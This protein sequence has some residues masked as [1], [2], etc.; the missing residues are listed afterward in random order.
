MEVMKDGALVANSGHFDVEINKVAL[1]EMATG[2]PRRVRPFVEQFTMKDGRRINLLG[3][4]A[5]DQ[6]GRR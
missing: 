1:A 5:P 2:E 6:P 4:R 3:R